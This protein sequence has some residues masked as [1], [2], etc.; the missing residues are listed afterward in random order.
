MQMIVAKIAILIVLQDHAILAQQVLKEA[1]CSSSFLFDQ[2]KVAREPPVLTK[3]DSFYFIISR[4][5]KT[6]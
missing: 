3:E 6:A 4:Q 2:S 1:F 5:G